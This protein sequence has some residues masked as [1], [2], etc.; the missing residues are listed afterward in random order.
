MLLAGG[1]GKD[2]SSA[3]ADLRP[4][5]NRFSIVEVTALGALAP[6]AESDAVAAAIARELSAPHT[7]NG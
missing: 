1:S 3:I 4:L 6:L 2:S 7:E 5:V